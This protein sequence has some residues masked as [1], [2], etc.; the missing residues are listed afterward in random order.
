MKVNLFMGV[1][2]LGTI[3]SSH[4]ARITRIVKEVKILHSGSVHTA[5]LN[6]SLAKGASI[7]TGVGAQAEMR[8]E[9]G[10]LVRLA[11]G[12]LL[13]LVDGPSRLELVRGA[14][15]ARAP[16][17]AGDARIDSGQVASAVQGTTS[18]LEFY[19]R[20]YT[21]L[22]VLDGTARMF[23]PSV[24]GESVLVEAGQLLM[25]QARVANAS[26]PNP[27]DIDLRRMMATSRLIRGFPALG[28]EGSIA[29]G[30]QGQKRQKSEGALADTNLVIFGRGTMV[31]LVPP[32]ATPSAKPKKS[33]ARTQRSR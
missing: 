15:L 13:R 16:K 14:I 7:Q 30:M 8:F 24:I 29:E 25:F 27:V 33:P 4:A 32:E 6:E 17:D 22:I 19:P 23:M 1:L 20:A 9:N 26:L 10:T 18:L 12:T 3:A 2:V 28:S 5:R 11:S 31:S 21:K